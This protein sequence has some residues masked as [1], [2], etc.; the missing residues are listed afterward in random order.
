MTLNVQ[1][2]V[3]SILLNQQHAR[4]LGVRLRWAHQQHHMKY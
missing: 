3:I 2:R 1:H 4:T